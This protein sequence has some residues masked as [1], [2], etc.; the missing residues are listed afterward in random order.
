MS[1]FLLT[2]RSGY[3]C[4]HGSNKNFLLERNDLTWSHLC[5]QK[6]PMQGIKQVKQEVKQ[7][8][9]MGGLR[10]AKR[11]LEEERKS[12]FIS[13]KPAEEPMA[14]LLKMV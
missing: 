5:T 10:E 8:R 7:R 11:V 9:L 12:I 3:V 14:S 13:V 4:L 6:L 1:Q 2:S